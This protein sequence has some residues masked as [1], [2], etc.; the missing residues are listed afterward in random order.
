MLPFIF[1]LE[2]IQ[3]CAGAVAGTFQKAWHFIASNEGHVLFASLATLRAIFYYLR[4]SPLPEA[5][6]LAHVLAVTLAVLVTIAVSENQAA[7]KTAFQC[8]KPAVPPEASPK[9]PEFAHR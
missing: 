6:D 2:A 1:D 9:A 4:R 8:K 3:P 7:I 5:Q